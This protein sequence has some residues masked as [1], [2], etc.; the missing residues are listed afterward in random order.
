MTGAGASPF[1][2]RTLLAVIA[3]GA[4]AFLL[5]LYAI[6]AG[7]DGED[8]N[9]GAHA[10]ATGLNGFAG[11]A[12]LLEE[13]D[14]EVTLSRSAGR[15]DEARSLLRAQLELDLDLDLQGVGR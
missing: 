7:W 4:G 6:G 5:L 8:R 12:R 11:F 9:G 1:S 10:A 14:H 13:L 2:P 3:V 15:L